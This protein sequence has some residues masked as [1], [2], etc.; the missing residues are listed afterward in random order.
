M[1]EF[2]FHGIAGAVNI[3]AFPH[4]E[5]DRFWRKSFGLTPER[6]IKADNQHFDE[7]DNA[8][9]K[10]K[11]PVQINLLQHLHKLSDFE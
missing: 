9:T 8:F 4:C 1:S 6:Y 3:F 2:S 5:T 10:P 7:C 11:P